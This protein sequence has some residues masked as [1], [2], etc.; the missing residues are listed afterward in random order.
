MLT[1]T[2]KRVPG[3]EQAERQSSWRRAA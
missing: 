1:D 3:G 2:R